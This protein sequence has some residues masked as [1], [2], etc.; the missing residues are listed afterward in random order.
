MS[1]WTRVQGTGI[2]PSGSQ[3]TQAV[4]YG[5][6]VTV[7][8]VL[9]STVSTYQ[10]YPSAFS[11]NLGNS[12]ALVKKN[13]YGSS[14]LSVYGCICTVGG[15]CTVTATIGNYI[16]MAIDEFASGGT[17]SQDGTAVYATGTGTTAASG[18]VTFSGGNDLL[19]GGANYNVTA[20]G[21]AWSSAGGFSLGY[22]VAQLGGHLPVCACYALNVSSSPSDP[23][24]GIA[25]SQTWGMIG[26]AFTYS[27]GGV[28]VPYSLLF[29]G[30]NGSLSDTP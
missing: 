8:N 1:T 18:N 10:A 14:Y 28:F 11:D 19:Y 27:A 22:N 29:T 30:T 23:S 15:A 25:S 9:L 5:S 2:Q 6:N 24:A 13:T 12:W 21:A 17:N 7:G 4:S 20:G 16:A 3:T 26:V